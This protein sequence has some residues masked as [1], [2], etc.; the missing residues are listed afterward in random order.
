MSWNKNLKFYNI[1]VVDQYFVEYTRI[2][3]LYSSILLILVTQILFVLNSN[4][5]C[6]NTFL[7]KY[8]ALE[9]EIMLNSKGVKKFNNLRMKYIFLK[10]FY[11]E[12]K[13]RKQFL[14]KI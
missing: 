7:K 14:S 6:I 11:K 8:S 2:I 4:P 13:A 3:P 12:Q 1:E 9:N 10:L 5:I